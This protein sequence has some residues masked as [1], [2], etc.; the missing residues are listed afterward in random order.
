MGGHR[1]PSEA[2]GSL[3]FELDTTIGT[4]LGSHG[5]LRKAIAGHGFDIFGLDTTIGTGSRAMGGH[6]TPWDGMSSATLA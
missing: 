6:G 4:G 2:M 3:S 1:K 5:K